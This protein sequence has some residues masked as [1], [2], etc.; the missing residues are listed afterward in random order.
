[1]VTEMKC[2]VTGMRLVICG[3]T[4]SE[5]LSTLQLTKEGLYI[6]ELPA[7]VIERNQFWKENVKRDAPCWC[8]TLPCGRQWV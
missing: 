2:V 1:V 5:Q 4:H 8:G 7:E 6:D 3:R